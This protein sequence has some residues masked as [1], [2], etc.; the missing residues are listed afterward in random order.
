MK[1][2]AILCS[3]LILILLLVIMVV[4]CQQKPT[5]APAPVTEPAIPT[6]FTTY[7]SE[8]FFSISYPQGWAPAISVMEEME[9]EAKELI[10]GI[11][12]EVEIEDVKFIFVGGKTT[13]EGWYPFVN[14][15]LAPREVGYYTLDEICE[16][17]DLWAREYMQRYKI[18]SQIRT[19]VDGREADIT[20]DE[21]YEPETGLWSYTSLTTVKD[22]FVWFVVCGS[23]SE[24]Y[25]EYEDIFNNIV[26]SLRILN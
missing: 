10:K 6:N 4:N 18:Y 5:P 7:T 15:T 11:D 25:N 12:P 8:D 23:E 9:K 26:R 16:A 3:T 14:I 20:C 2:I 17:E 22:D 19:V 24:D 21:D 13:E 1:R